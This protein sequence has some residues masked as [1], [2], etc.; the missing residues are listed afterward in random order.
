MRSTPLVLVARAATTT[1]MRSVTVIDF[2]SKMETPVAPY[3][4]AHLE[5]MGLPM[6]VTVTQLQPQL[7]AAGIDVGQALADVLPRLTPDES[8]LLTATLAKPVPLQYFFFVDGL[9][10]IEPKTG[11]LI[12]VHASERAWRCSPT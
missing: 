11:A 6:Q 8:T 10:S 3:Y 4:R 12:D 2:T 5:A 9:V 7:P 1:P